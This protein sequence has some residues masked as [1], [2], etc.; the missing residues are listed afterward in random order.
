MDTPTLPDLKGIVKM[1]PLEMNDVHFDK[2]HT[3]ISPEEL[4]KD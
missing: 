4:D 2:K 3:V 1:T